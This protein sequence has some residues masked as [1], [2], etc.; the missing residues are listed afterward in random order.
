LSACYGAIFN[1]TLAYHFSDT[2][3]NLSSVGRDASVLS[4]QHHNTLNKAAGVS[5]QNASCLPSQLGNRTTEL[6]QP[7]LLHSRGQQRLGHSLDPQCHEQQ[8]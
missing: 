3:C 7:C 6:L 8:K 4:E 2:Y 5:E 1:Y